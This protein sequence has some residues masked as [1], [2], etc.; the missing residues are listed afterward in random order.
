MRK[1]IKEKDIRDF[2]K[3]AKKLNDVICRIQEYN[4]DANVYLA[5]EDLCLMS[6]RSHDD[7]GYKQPENI[8]TSVIITSA[9]GG[10]W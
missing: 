4:Q 6:G 1:G 9:N 7:Y 3:Y 8:V 10:D 5:M 2:E